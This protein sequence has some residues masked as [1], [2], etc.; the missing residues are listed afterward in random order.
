MSMGLRAGR[1]DD[2]VCVF[3]VSDLAGHANQPHSRFTA[4]GLDSLDALVGRVA[5]RIELTGELALEFQEL[6]DWHPDEFCARIPAMAKLLEIDRELRSGRGLDG[7]L[8]ELITATG[9]KPPTSDETPEPTQG[10]DFVN[11]LLTGN[12]SSQAQPAG[13]AMLSQFLEHAVG[14]HV[15][16]NDDSGQREAARAYIRQSASQLVS[17]VLHHDDW[18]ALEARWRGLAWLLSQIDVGDEVHVYVS[19]S[20]M[21]TDVASVATDLIGTVTGNGLDTRRCLIVVDAESSEISADAVRW[22]TELADKTSLPIYSGASSALLDLAERDAD[23]DRVEQWNALRALPGAD[24]TLLALPRF[25]MRLPYGQDNDP[26]DTFAYEEIGG[27]NDVFLWGNAG[28]AC[29][30]AHVRSL[31]GDDNAL[32]MDDVSTFTY[33]ALNRPPTMLALEHETLRA[34]EVSD[35][36]GVCVLQAPRNRSYVQITAWTPL[37]PTR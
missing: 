19:P 13:D 29:A 7:A 10:D 28:L 30:V 12:R 21:A 27:K 26:I 20:G 15:V 5:P 32:V 16:R 14:P 23:A 37:A 17:S 31:R 2:P 35:R 18:L 1:D 24:R 25:L 6:E 3:V 33:R 36:L 8:E 34:D 22:I 4:V 11:Q 9:W